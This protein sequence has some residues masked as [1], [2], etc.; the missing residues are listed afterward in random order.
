MLD[1]VKQRAYSPLTMTNTNTQQ[2]Q[3][4]NTGEAGV[5]GCR[6][7]QG[8]VVHA[9]VAMTMRNP[10]SGVEFQAYKPLCGRRAP[11]HSL[12]YGYIGTK[13]AVNCGACLTKRG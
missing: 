2:T 13:E 10:N 7:I 5:T 9:P 1:S 8:K 6:L 11:R 12:T 4:T 3:L